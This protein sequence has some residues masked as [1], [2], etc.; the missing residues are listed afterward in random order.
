MSDQNHLHHNQLYAV[1]LLS[2]DHI[3]INAKRKYCDLKSKEVK[4]QIIYKRYLSYKERVPT[5]SMTAVKRNPNEHL[6]ID[7]LESLI[8]KFEWPNFCLGKYCA[9]WCLQKTGIL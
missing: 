7:T 6:L 3:M 8:T 9:L 5:G 2:L 1:M 4:I